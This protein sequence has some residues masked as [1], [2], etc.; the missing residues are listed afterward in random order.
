VHSSARFVVEYQQMEQ[1]IRLDVPTLSDPT[2]RDLLSESDIFVSSF[3]AVA[4]FGLLSPFDFIR[5][6]TLLSELVS[7]LFVLSSITYGSLPL[8]TLAFT[9]LSAVYPFLQQYFMPYRYGFEGSGFGE[10]EMRQAEKQE[11][12]RQLSLSESHRP[13]VMLF[14]LGPWILHTWARARKAGLGLQAPRTPQQDGIPKLFS[15]VN[16]VD[17][18]SALQNVS[19]LALHDQTDSLRAF[20]FPRYPSL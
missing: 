4:G 7:H 20:S 10:E 1:R 17:M 9:L 6:V 16:V 2:I 18:I 19:S 11:Q 5:I 14:G 15:H 8:F 12:M 13:E 3:Q